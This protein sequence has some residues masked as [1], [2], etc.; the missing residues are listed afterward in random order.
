MKLIWPAS[1]RSTRLP[2]TLL[3]R[4][5]LTSLQKR[6]LLLLR[7][8]DA[9]ASALRARIDDAERR[10]DPLDLRSS[11]AFRPGKWEAKGLPEE[12]ED[13]RVSPSLRVGAAGDPQGVVDVELQEQFFEVEEALG[14]PRHPGRVPAPY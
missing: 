6:P 10:A 9:D 11:L 5:V 3:L 12:K 13:D 7:D 8:L 2:T 4:M 14:A 1:F